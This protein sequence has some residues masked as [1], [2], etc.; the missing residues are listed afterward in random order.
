MFL[1]IIYFLKIMYGIAMMVN[2][3]RRIN[4]RASLKELAI[5]TETI[6]LYIEFGF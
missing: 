6:L 2:S 4:P 5:K 3:L 1:N